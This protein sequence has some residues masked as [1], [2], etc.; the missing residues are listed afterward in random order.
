[1]PAPFSTI[2]IKILSGLLAAL[3]L[4]SFGGAVSWFALPKGELQ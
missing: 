4:L 2:E 1:M 3:S